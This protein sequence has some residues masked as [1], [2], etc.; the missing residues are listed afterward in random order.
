MR[1]ESTPYLTRRA[2][3]IGWWC[4][5]LPTCVSARRPT[6]APLRTTRWCPGRDVRG[7]GGDCVAV[8]AAAAWN[9]GGGERE[10]RNEPRPALPP[11]LHPGFLPATRP[12]TFYNRNQHTSILLRLLLLALRPPALP[13]PFFNRSGLLF[14][15]APAEGKQSIPFNPNKSPASSR[16]PDLL[17]LYLLRGRGGG[18]G[19]I[20]IWR[21]AVKRNDGWSP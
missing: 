20:A 8:A 5:W 14:G 4:W 6:S 18:G 10:E 21:F 3:S 13:P 12:V 19:S 7:A 2:R 17:L 11:H 16:S 9:V 1:A 15:L